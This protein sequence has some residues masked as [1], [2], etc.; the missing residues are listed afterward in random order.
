MTKCFLCAAEFLQGLSGYMNVLFNPSPLVIEG[1]A[2]INW[3]SSM[4]R[5]LQRHTIFAIQLIILELDKSSHRLTP[6]TLQGTKGKPL[7]LNHKRKSSYWENL[8]QHP[9]RPFSFFIIF[10][11]VRKARVLKVL[12]AEALQLNFLVL[13]YVF[14]WYEHEN[15]PSIW[16]W[17]IHPAH[18]ASFPF[19]FIFGQLSYAARNFLQSYS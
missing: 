16:Q 12:F 5:C 15:D 10:Y 7:D 3:Q 4:S 6:C 9:N 19:T 2:C 11:G 8:L 14:V 13:D 1:G 17:G 18:V